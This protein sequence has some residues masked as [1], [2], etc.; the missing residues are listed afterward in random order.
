M[1]LEIAILEDNDLDFS[2]LLSILNEWRHNTE[3][4]TKITR[5]KDETIITAFEHNNYDILFADIELKTTKNHTG[6]SICELLRNRGFNNEIIFL[7]AFSEYVFQGYTVRAFN[8]LVKPIS[9]EILTSCLKRYIN[10]HTGD[11]YC[12][13]DR[14]SLLQIRYGE[15]LYIQKQG[16][17]ISFHTQKNIYYERSTLNKII[18]ALPPYFLQC[19]KSCIINI[20]HVQSILGNTAHLSDGST[21]TIGRSYLTEIRNALLDLSQF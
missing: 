8:Y 15:I 5:F 11:C 18:K 20:T 16:H 2:H 10:Y 7:T 9:L 3:N 12:L 6:I 13:Q 19:H 1:N 21:Q 14:S 4:N 17:N